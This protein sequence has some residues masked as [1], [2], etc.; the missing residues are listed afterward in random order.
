MLALVSSIH[1]LGV[2]QP[3]LVR[4][5]DDDTASYELVA[6]ERRWRAARRAGLQTM[7]VLV[8]TSTTDVH[9]LEQALVENLHREDLNSLEEAAPEHHVIAFAQPP[10]AEVGPP[11]WC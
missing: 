1:E 6:G 10:A 11:R 8:Q 2:L 4:T 3:I 7:P 5:V 9:S